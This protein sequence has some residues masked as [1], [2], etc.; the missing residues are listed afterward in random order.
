MAKNA[1]NESATAMVEA[2]LASD[3]EVVQRKKSPQDAS[4]TH[5]STNSDLAPAKRT[6]EK[7]TSTTSKELKKSTP[8]TKPDAKPNALDYVAHY[9]HLSFTEM[10]FNNVDMLILAML[11]YA[12]F[13]NYSENFCAP[14]GT[15]PTLLSLLPIVYP[16]PIPAKTSYI[17]RPRYE[18]WQTMKTHRR[19]AEIRLDRFAFKFDPSA[20]EQFAA[21]V[22]CCQVGTSKT[23]IVSFRGTDATVI[24]WREDFDMAYKCPI[25]AQKDSLQFL[26]SVLQQGYDKI[27]LCGHSKGGNL[28]MYSAA[29]ATMAYLISDIYNF[30]GPGLS[31]DI[32]SS[33]GWAKIRSKVHS[34]VPESSII[35]ML[36]G[37]ATKPF[38]VRS[39]SMSIMQHN[40]FYW[41]VQGTNFVEADNRTASSKFFDGTMQNLLAMCTPQQKETVVRT[42][43]EIIQ[44][45][46]ANKMKDVVK[47]LLPKLSEVISVISSIPQEERAILRQVLV[48]LLG[49]AGV[50]VLQLLF[51]S[52]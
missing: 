31:D 20:D 39:S 18:L 32:I 2:L 6:S 4:L 51:N 44:I 33:L 16:N 50:A 11:S 23:A 12:A 14:I 46:G 47:G 24:G 25:P 9:G 17:F 37:C 15:G 5:N 41:H 35:G 27:I 29:K 7:T 42:V 10:P 28:S 40:P 45:S 1:K 43:F 3:L 21:A 36:L 48:N 52:N 49:S 30:D 13:E 22:F 19:F 26:E 8:A 38:V 34:F